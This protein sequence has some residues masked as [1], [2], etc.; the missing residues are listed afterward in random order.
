MIPWTC[1]SAKASRRIYRTSDGIASSVDKTRFFSSVVACA[2]LQL[3]KMPDNC[4]QKLLEIHRTALV[5]IYCTPQQFNPIF[6]YGILV[7]ANPFTNLREFVALCTYTRQ[8]QVCVRERERER[9][10]EIV[11]V[12]ACR[13]VSV[14]SDGCRVY[15]RSHPIT[16]EPFCLKQAHI[17]ECKRAKHNACESEYQSF[18]CHLYQ[19]VRTPST[20]S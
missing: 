3:D 15:L 17:H 6:A 10:R 8:L 1:D 14:Y 7:H 19:I 9:E 5:P 13:V 2:K 11:C 12:C 16:H 4:R 18:R 20:D